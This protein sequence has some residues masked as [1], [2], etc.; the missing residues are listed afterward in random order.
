M[1]PKIPIKNLYYLFCYAWN[2]WEESSVV[3]VDAVE[4][5]ELADLFATVLIGGVNHLVR[6]G[7]DR[8]YVPVSEEMRE[9]RGRINIDSSLSSIARRSAHLVC[10]FDDLRHDVPNNQILKSTI[11]RLAAVLSLDRELARKL[12]HLARSFDGVSAPRLSK[13]LFH[14]VQ[15]HRNNA[16][17]GFLLNVCELIFDATLPEGNGSRYRFTEILRDEKKM[18]YVFQ[19][20]VRNFYRLEQ[21][22]F[23]V[24]GLQLEWDISIADENSRQHFPKMN[25]DTYLESTNR[26]II[27]DTKYYAEALQTHREKQ[28]IN[29]GHLYQIFAYVKNAE[30]RT[31]L[32]V[33]EGM[34]LYPAVGEKLSLAATIQ[35]H[36]IK[37]ETVSLDQPWQSIRQQL[38]DLIGV[39][40]RLSH[41]D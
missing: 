16:Y 38:L 33:A 40:T 6:R 29:S 19:D 22:E 2:R 24:S 7:L 9:L 13:Q 3:S 30:K 12:R 15:I 10:E 28:T 23:R 36:L 14:R 26:R 32:P 1:D 8:D 41:R 27:I 21:R 5:P 34:L 11:I 25:T 4:S 18:A 35:D 39:G 20:F 31:N 17:Y 37:I